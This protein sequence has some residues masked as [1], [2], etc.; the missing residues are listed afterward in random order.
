MRTHGTWRLIAVIATAVVVGAVAASASASAATWTGSAHGKLVRSDGRLVSG[1]TSWSGDFWFT[2]TRR[3]EVRGF[4]V[5]ACEP[6]VDVSGLNSALGYVRGIGGA[7]LGM[8]GPFG[9]GVSTVA[10][11]QIVGAGVSFGSSEAIR[12]APLTGRLNGRELVLDWKKPKGIPYD[13]NLVLASG[14][15]KIGGGTVSLRSAFQ[16]TGKLMGGRAAVH[17]SEKRSTPG[18]IVQSVGSY[19]IATRVR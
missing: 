8:L 15:K 9:S 19:W 3:G 5:V 2:T 14:A 6:L 1:G 13:I 16:G 11:G 17:S 18:G 4:A 10:L 7:A 12:R